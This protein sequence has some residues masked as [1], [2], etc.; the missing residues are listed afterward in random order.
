MGNTMIG[1]CPGGRTVDDMLNRYPETRA[2]RI[3]VGTRDPL[4]A[5]DG[6][7]LGPLGDRVVPHLSF[8]RWEP[9]LLRAWAW[10]KP[11]GRLLILTYG[12]EPEQGPAEGDPPIDVWRTRWAELVNLLADHPERHLILLVPTYTRF[13]WQRN[14]GDL[15]WLVAYPGIDA[16]GWDIYSAEPDRYRT[17][18]DLLSIPRD[19]AARTGLPYLIAE[20]GAV[21]IAGDR[22][23]SGRQAWMRAMVAA[24]AADR[25]ITCCW[26]HKDAWDLAAAGAEPEGQTWADITRQEALVGRWTDIA[27]WVGPTVNQGGPMRRHD[28]VVLHI[29][30]GSYDGTIAW[31]KNPAADVSSHF[32]VAKDGRIAQMVDTDTTAWTQRD[33]NG[34]WLSIENEGRLPTA[35]T[36]AQVEANARILA[37][38]HQVYGVPL[39]VTDTPTKRGLGHH[40][41]GAENGF[42]WGHPSCP[43]AA[44]KAQKAAIVARAQQI[45]NG[46]DDTMDQATFDKLLAGS[47]TG[48]STDAKAV[49]ANLRALPWAYPVRPDASALNVLFAQQLPALAAAVKTL[50]EAVAR[51][52]SNP[53][54]IRAL[55]AALP[56]PEPLDVDEI[57][58]AVAERV[59]AAL[60]DSSAGPV[61]REDLEAALR[62]ALGSLDGATPQG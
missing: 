36:D 16:I 30:E 23:G 18:D 19:I 1:W 60:P 34:E 54:E 17:P 26:F 13:W 15:R 42:D 22:D 48:K 12:H 35:L 2:V 24:A 43:G 50:G 46:E 32:I 40:S 39:Q 41:M 5:W 44:I 62:S 49:Q 27:Q 4:P 31:Q 47:L 9:E 28:G 6:P 3:F 37:K 33:G 11:P 29:A 21:R 51:E 53:D 25:A 38:A 52:S 14:A 57:A 7:I 8:K 61:S 45:I 20:L 58:G 55:L 59:L 10:A 56:K